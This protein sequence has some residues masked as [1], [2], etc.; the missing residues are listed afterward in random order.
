[1]NNQGLLSSTVQMDLMKVYYA[2][3]KP[4]KINVGSGCAQTHSLE[5]KICID[6]ENNA[7]V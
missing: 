1:M 7:D 6:L 3:Q 4:S 2:I 5:T